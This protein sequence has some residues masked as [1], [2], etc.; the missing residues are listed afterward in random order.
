MTWDFNSRSISGFVGS[1]NLG[2][3]STNHRYKPNLSNNVS[4]NAKV[5]QDTTNYYFGIPMHIQPMIHE[6][7]KTLSE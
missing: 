4:I 3:I 7:S 2:G 5:K 6:A 1:L